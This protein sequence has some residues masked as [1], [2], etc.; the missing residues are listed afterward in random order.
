VSTSTS[1]N[2]GKA[3]PGG[4]RVARASPTNAATPRPARDP[5]QGAGGGR[6]AA[7]HDDGHR[8]GEEHWRRARVQGRVPRGH[9]LLPQHDEPA[10][11]RGDQNHLEHDP[12][13][14]ARPPAGPAGRPAGGRSRHTLRDHAHQHGPGQRHRDR[15][16]SQPPT[17]AIAPPG[18]VRRRPAGPAR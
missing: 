17:H 12:P 1:A 16:A 14:C 2:A 6:V 13:G 3:A 8:D 18:D 9:A 10:D 11:R 7:Q 5:G 15:N 4:V